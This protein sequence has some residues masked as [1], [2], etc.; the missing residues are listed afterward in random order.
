MLSYRRGMNRISFS[1]ECSCSFCLKAL[2]E[3]SD[4][5]VIVGKF[6]EKEILFEDAFE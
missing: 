1:N 2:V 6:Y 5:G 4:K 3:F